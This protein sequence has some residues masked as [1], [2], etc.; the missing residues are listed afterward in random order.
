VV[1]PNRESSSRIASLL[2]C[3][4]PNENHRRYIRAD[5]G[6]LCSHGH[7][8]VLSH[9]AQDYDYSHKDPRPSD[10]T[11]VTAIAHPIE[12][13]GLEHN[14]VTEHG[15]LPTLVLAHGGARLHFSAKRTK[16][17]ENLEPER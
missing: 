14:Q 5:H 11:E 1:E 9:R 2:P 13:D 16:H 12:G 17:A 4:L 15:R 8:F 6:G 3:S 7:A 10:C